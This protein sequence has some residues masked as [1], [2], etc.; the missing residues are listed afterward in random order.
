MEN[1]EDEIINRVSESGLIQFEMDKLKRIK[2]VELDITKW[3]WQGAVVREKEIREHVKNLTSENYKG[4][5]VG[6]TVAEGS[7]IPDWAWML[8]TAKLPVAEFVVMGGMAGA[9][10]ESLRKAIEDISL[11]DFRDKRIV[12]RGC[13]GVGGPEELMRL[14]MKLQPAVKSL[15]FGEACSTVPV[16]KQKTTK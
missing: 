9:E 7:I 6:L 14:Q 13:G 16:F 3:L 15:M 8:I 10:K 2:T 11:D 4:L 5:G 12:V 1:P